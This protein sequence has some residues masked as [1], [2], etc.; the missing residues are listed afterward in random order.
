MTT[1]LYLVRVFAVTEATQWIAADSPTEA[2]LRAESDY[3]KH[4]LAHFRV[5]DARVA[6][7]DIEDEHQIGGHA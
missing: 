6:Q 4:K 5:A 2:K 3:R 1:T 7:S